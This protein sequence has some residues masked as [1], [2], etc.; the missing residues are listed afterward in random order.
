MDLALPALLVVFA[1]VDTFLIARSLPRQSFGDEWRYVYYAE[2]L[3][4]GFF[5]PTPR[6]FIWNGPAYPVMLV[7]FVKLGWLDGGRYLNVLFHVGALGYAW[8]LLR[9]R[10]SAG[11][12]L[13][14]VALFGL[15]PPLYEHL[16]LF[17]TELFCF[18]LVTGW[19][20]HSLRTG[21][22][23]TFVAGVYLGLLCLTKVV[24]GYV[25]VVFWI[26]MLALWARER[27]RVW[28]D[29]V[30][31]C[32]L[33]FAL[34]I[35][36][37]NYTH[38]LTGRV[39]YWS[40]G[41][42]NSFYWLAS[43]YRGELGDWYHHGWVY[44]NPTLRKNHKTVFDHITG[45]DENP[46]VSDKEALFNLCTPESSDYL[47]TTALNGIKKRPRKFAYNWL[48]NIP[49]M[50]FALPVTVRDVSFWNKYALSSVVLFACTAAVMVRA[51]RP[52][53]LP[54]RPWWGTLLFGIL[55]MGAYSLSSAVARYLI[56]MVPIWWLGLCY[57][58][59]AKAR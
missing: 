19:M 50:F 29:Y 32:A 33:A 3:V 52:W 30:L 12:A 49:R 21:L 11:L 13:A 54:P 4:Q 5:S 15:Y 51:K 42:A 17:Y 47:M 26:V 43:P 16:P 9:E 28:R 48:L 22:V 39:F 6:L 24:F 53:S 10:L 59:A 44:N 7:P 36:Y 23:H 2:N 14:A 38:R 56:P 41:G 34:C 18:F 57:W 27:R 35:P 58:A 40:S 31:Q 46:E 20:Y 55:T 25:L 1:A 8:L 45:R 37:L